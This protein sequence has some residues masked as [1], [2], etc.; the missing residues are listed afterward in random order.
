MKK[1]KEVQEVLE[2]DE[3]LEDVEETDEV[4][5]L[6]AKQVAQ[7]LGT[8]GRTFRKFLRSQRGKVGQGNRWAIDPNE[9]EDL[10]KGFEAFNKPKAPVEAK[11]IV[12]E[13]DEDD[14]VFE[15]LADEL[16]DIEIG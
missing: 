7:L 14:D 5:T 8:D 6:S 13:I 12:P 2:E 15:D 10:R 9:V 11:V 4:T 1:E 3:I 16:E